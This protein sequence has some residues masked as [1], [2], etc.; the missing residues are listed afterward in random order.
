MGLGPKGVALPGRANAV[1]TKVKSPWGVGGRVRAALLLAL[2]ALLPAVAQAQEA[3]RYAA[4]S[5]PDAM[6]LIGLGEGP[7]PFAW[8]PQGRGVRVALLDTGL[9]PSH[10]DLQGVL[11]CSSCWRDFVQ[12]RARPYDDHGHGTH[13]AGILAARGHVQL[14]PSRAYFPGG[15]RGVAPG[16]GLLVAKAMDAR[17]E[18]SDEVVAQALRWALDPDGEPATQDGADVINLSIGLDEP[19]APAP[20]RVLGT[21][22]RVA[23][24]EALERG[25][26]V[27]ASSGN[28]AAPRVREPGDVPDVLTVGAADGR[29]AMAGFTNRGPGLDVLAPGVLVST[30]PLVLDT[31]DGAQDGYTTMAGTSMAAPVVAGTVALLLEARPDLQQGR[32]HGPGLA[33]VRAVHAL[34]VGTARP[35]GEGPGIVDAQA[36]LAAAAP[37]TL[38][39]P[40]LL[41]AALGGALLAP[42]LPLGLALWERRADVKAIA[43]WRA[44]RAPQLGSAPRRDLRQLSVAAPRPRR[45]RPGS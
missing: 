11:A 13:V 7:L 31:R 1:P 23:L 17:G 41:L 18:G 10:P 32:G 44:R 2:L 20:R 8:Q 12:G 25:V 14:D 15:A 45:L 21:Q 29:G 4:Q 33:R 43:A 30:Y 36:A 27:V 37:G 34:V 28:D 19:A 16:A 5:L 35:Q 42:A 38:A 22:T 3:P 6:R 24:T 9:D 26:V 39:L 40:G